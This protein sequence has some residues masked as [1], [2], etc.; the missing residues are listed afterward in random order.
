MDIFLLIA[1][2]SVSDDECTMATASYA[3]KRCAAGSPPR[4]SGSHLSSRRAKRCRGSPVPLGSAP[5]DLSVLGDE[6]KAT[7]VKAAASGTTKRTDQQT[8]SERLSIAKERR[9]AKE[10]LDARR[11]AEFQRHA[12]SRESAALLRASCHLKSKT[13]RARFDQK[14]RLAKERREMLETKRTSSLRTTSKIRSMS[15][16]ERVKENLQTKKLKSN[17]DKR[18]T[19]VRSRRSDL[20]RNRRTHLRTNLASRIESATVRAEYALETKAS[21]AK[22]DEYRTQRARE[23][24]TMLEYE[25]R[26]EL[27][28]DLDLRIERAARNADLALETK[29]SKAG[30]GVRHARIVARRV[31]AARVIQDAFRRQRQI[32]TEARSEETLRSILVSKRRRAGNDVRHARDVSRRVRAARAIQ[33][34]ARMKLHGPSEARS[35]QDSCQGGGFG[36]LSQNEAAARIQS[37][38]AWRVKVVIR[39][40]LK[41]V[42]STEADDGETTKSP[43][44]ALHSVLKLFTKDGSFDRSRAAMQSSIVMSDTRTVLQALSPVTLSAVNERTLLSAF[45]IATH[46]REVLG[47]DN[48]NSTDS[49]VVEW[50]SRGL[51]ALAQGLS[52]SLNADPLSPKSST[53]TDVAAI[54]SNIQ[55]KASV[56]ASSF[57]Q[58]KDADLRSMVSGMESSAEQSWVVYLTSSEALEYLDDPSGG[59][60]GEGL[61]TNPDTQA[62]HGSGGGDDPLL[63]IRLRHQ[64]S[65]SGARSHLKRIR[66]SLNRLVGSDEGRR[67]MRCAKEVALDQIREEGLED[68]F[69]REVEVWRGNRQELGSAE[70]E[71]ASDVDSS[72]DRTVENEKAS[73]DA[74]KHKRTRLPPSASSDETKTC[75]MSADPVVCDILSSNEELVHRILLTDPSDFS[76]LTWN[77]MPHVECF[78]AAT[79]MAKWKQGTAIM[80]PLEPSSEQTIEQ[81]LSEEIKFAFFDRVREDLREHR[82]DSMRRLAMELNEKICE[83]GSTELH[84]HLCEKF[85]TDARTKVDCLRVLLKAAGILAANLEAP[86]RA[87]TTEEWINEVSRFQ[88][89]SDGSALP[90]DFASEEDLCVA[91]LAFLFF[92]VDLCRM[93]ISNVQLAKMAPLIHRLG[94]DYKASKFEEKYCKLNEPVEVLRKSIPETW[95]WIHTIA[96][97]LNSTDAESLSKGSYQTRI[98]LFKTRGFVDGLIFAQG[99]LNVPEVLSMDMPCIMDARSEARFAVIGSALSL[100]VCNASGVGASALASQPLPSSLDMERKRLAYVLR[101][102]HETHQSLV[103]SVTEVALQMAKVLKATQLDQEADA[104]LRN[105]AASVLRGTD[106]VLKLLDNR[107]RQLFRFMSKWEASAKCG[108]AVPTAMK[109]GRSTLK[110]PHSSISAN[111]NT[112]STDAFL[113]AVQKEASKLGFAFFS[114]ELAKTG[115]KMLRVIALSCSVF[116]EQVFDKILTSACGDNGD[117]VGGI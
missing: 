35:H 108:A 34:A 28:C 5:P 94:C 91:S 9:K 110:G 15:A 70:E 1:P 92:K 36:E 76:T 19:M 40:F 29:R 100:H 49:Q 44:A 85:V 86:A 96:S 18:L 12:L 95:A 55:T 68:E 10:D 73:T 82:F 67:V 113:A 98:A 114:D 20:E 4:L 25:R 58:W 48:G 75:S 59:S 74:A 97:S 11:L 109:T 72:R 107:M 3:E 56:F 112:S 23:R 31:R 64:A 101:D 53:A 50:A 2:S 81:Q 88:S 80:P 14:I 93:D 117:R 47:D 79:F 45:L 16:A 22:H 51:L 7:K 111:E 116:G 42:I 69:K 52:R 78:T 17:S 83:L 99:A 102:K 57:H 106:P 84:R 65:R 6:N 66:L 87:V 43:V 46:P 61:T 8:V 32:L 115:Q 62:F 37:W 26:A 103:G 71:T 27:L 63:P 104:T 77:G 38:M 105:C 13:E 89:L 30:E 33:Q 24:R 90:F 41:P 21:K 39:R 54:L 60:N